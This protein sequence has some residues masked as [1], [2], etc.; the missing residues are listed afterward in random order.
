MFRGR[1][2]RFMLS[3]NSLDLHL[4]MEISINFKDHLK[5]VVY[6]ALKKESCVLRILKRIFVL[7]NYLN[8]FNKQ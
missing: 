6:N 1:G 8:N 7:E 4:Y 2:N 5:Y 3:F